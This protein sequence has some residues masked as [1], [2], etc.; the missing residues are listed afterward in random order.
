MR[1]SLFVAL[2]VATIVAG[3][4]P[5]TSVV[6]ASDAANAVHVAIAVCGNT[7]C[8]MPQT[9]AVRQRKVQ[10]LGRG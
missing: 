9:K 5:A 4:M 6:A 2:T 10:S 1:T 3:G 8:Y 7:G